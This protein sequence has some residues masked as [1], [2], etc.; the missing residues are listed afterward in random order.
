MMQVLESLV[1]NAIHYTLAEGEV[2]VSVNEERADGH[3]WAV[4]AVSDTG[5]GIPPEE[6]PHV[7]ERFFRGERARLMD[8]PGTGLGL[9]ISREIVEL[10]GGR[11]MVESKVD[12]GS[13]F[14]IWLPVA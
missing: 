12:E 3:V 6:M 4:V 14:A 10:H 9:A 13:T 11:M 2:V 5:I 7:F 1:T 8:V